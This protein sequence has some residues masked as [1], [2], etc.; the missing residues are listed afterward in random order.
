MERRSRV[1]TGPRLCSVGTIVSVTCNSRTFYIQLKTAGS[2]EAGQPACQPSGANITDNTAVWLLVNAAT[3]YCIQLDTGSIET[4][5]L[6]TD[7]T[8]GA[9][10]NIAFTNTYAGQ[11][12][13]QNRVS[14][15]TP[16]GGFNGNVLL[17]SGTHLT[18]IGVETSFCLFTGCAGIL[19][20]N[21]VVS[22][23]KISNL[24]C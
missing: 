15:S 5:I 24:D 18:L 21:A 9:G 3:S 10:Y 13:S 22:S 8:C 20:D 1:G 19:I 12:P 6:H 11:A 14:M 23:V 17:D 2:S 16:G 4:E 7:A